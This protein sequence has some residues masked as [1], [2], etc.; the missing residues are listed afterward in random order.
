MDPN[1]LAD[2]DRQIAQLKKELNSLFGKRIAILQDEIARSEAEAQ[3][4]NVA[5]GPSAS[6]PKVKRARQAKPFPVNEE[7]P[8][9]AQAKA[10]SQVAAPIEEEKKTETKAEPDPQ[11]TRRRAPSPDSETPILDALR[12]AGLFGLTVAE[13]SEKTSLSS[14]AI[15]KQ[16]KELPGITKKGTGKEARYYLKS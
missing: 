16:L 3:A 12:E 2:V 6:Q 4:L 14:Q 5:G 1:A 7:Q 8:S 9:P 15:T 11:P 13:V 10:P